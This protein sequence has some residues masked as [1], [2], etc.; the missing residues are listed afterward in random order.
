MNRHVLFYYTEL[1]TISEILLLHQQHLNFVDLCD[2]AG[3]IRDI[4]LHGLLNAELAESGTLLH[5]ACQVIY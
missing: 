4:E 1:F 2:V 3:E 5:L